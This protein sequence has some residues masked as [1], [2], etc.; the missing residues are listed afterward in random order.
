MRLCWI[1]ALLVI[2]APVVLG[3]QTPVAPDAEEVLRRVRGRLLADLDRLPRYTCVQTITRR[4]YR[5]RS[6]HASC[7]TL[8]AEHDQRK[9]SLKLS[10]WDR[11]R[12]E[13]AI[14]QGKN[15]F[16]WVGE[17]RFDN[18]TLQRLG[19]GGPI[20]SGDFGP[21]LHAILSRASV[22]FKEQI[23]AANRQLLAY[24]YDMPLAN[25][26]YMVQTNKSWTPSAY[27]GVLV[28]DPEAGDPEAGDAKAGD[29]VS[30]T[31][32]TAELPESNPDCQAISEVYYGR[33]EIHDRQILIPRETRLINITRNGSEVHS[34]TEYASCREYAA[35]SRILL[36]DAPE[37]QTT[38]SS[39]P[40][41]PGAPSSAPP[42]NAAPSSALSGPGA[43][44]SATP[45]PITPFPAGLHFRARIIT[46]IDSDNAAAGD[47]VEAV[48]QS[49]IRGRN[50]VELAPAGTRL[51]ARLVGMEE[52]Y[53]SYFRLSLQFESIE[54]KGVAVPLRATPDRSMP[55]GASI[56][57]SP[58]FVTS[59]P[60][61]EDV[62][63]LTFSRQHL[64]LEQ[65]DWS[66]TTLGS[67]AG[68][69][70]GKAR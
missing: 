57:T 16:S 41:A 31:V 28:I 55:N 30:L 58:V 13:V 70:R 59:T 33:T 40:P 22:T 18:N 62:T 60:Y 8:I 34:Q 63:Y 23:P 14:V 15:V 61:T 45:T 27:S 39:T 24:S 7:S 52:V 5:A 64:H 42:A 47:R 3:Q 9:D 4:Y 48:L 46:L 67:R 51:H 37:L 53:G 25:S 65:F 26:S 17:P 44:S 69:E 11:L 32:R 36:D 10:V 19:G 29:I 6:G 66:W 1:I 43:P 21:F 56:A 49:P 2:A 50:N 20:G 38:P 35:K 68:D 54:L 12:L